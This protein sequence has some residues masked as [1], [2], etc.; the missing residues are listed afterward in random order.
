[1]LA[2]ADHPLPESGGVWLSL[3]PYE[4]RIFHLPTRPAPKRRKKSQNNVHRVAA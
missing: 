1:V 3:Q 4:A 2:D